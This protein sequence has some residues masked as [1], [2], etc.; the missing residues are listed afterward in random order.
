MHQLGVD[1]EVEGRRYPQH[2]VAHP[3]RDPR[4]QH[5][6]GRGEGEAP[7]PGL[8]EEPDARERAQDTVERVLLRAGIGGELRGGGLGRHGGGGHAGHSMVSVGWW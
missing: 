3:A 5:P 8:V 7:R 2:H 4:S 1:A 6:A